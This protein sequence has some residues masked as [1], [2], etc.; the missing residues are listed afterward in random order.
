MEERFISKPPSPVRSAAYIASAAFGIS[1]LAGLL[2]QWLDDGIASAWDGVFWAVQTVTT[3]GY[4]SP[5]PT[6]TTGQL[7]AMLLMLFGTA[8]LAVVTAA[9]TS[10]FVERA[11]AIRRSETEDDPRALLEEIITRLD[12]L[13]RGLDER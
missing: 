10:V 13:E 6:G 3:V 5:M 12:R 7:L 2:A 9:I 8:F 11:H 1:V 4:G